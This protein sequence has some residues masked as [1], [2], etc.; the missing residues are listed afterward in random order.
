[1]TTPEL[2]AL[3]KKNPVIVICGALS[4]AL[5]GALYFRSG[6]IEAA[7]TA[8]DEKSAEGNRY[9]QNSTN[10]VQLK[11]QLDAIVAANVT[12]EGRMIRASDLGINQQYFYK[13]ESDSGVKL[14]D[15]RQGGKGNLGP[16]AKH[17]PIGFTMSVQ[18]DFAQ[19]LTFL[20]TL[21]DGTHYCRVL[22]ATCGGG[23]KGTVTLTLNLEVLGRP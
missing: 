4:L 13:L 6:D 20:R 23:R 22:T 10:A 11:E 12:I 17:I 7:N 15:L 19:V 2:V 3:L 1:M 18:G 5:A 8:L 14:S 16:D 9:T 21:E